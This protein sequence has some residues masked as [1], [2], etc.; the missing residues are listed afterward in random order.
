VSNGNPWQP[1]WPIIPPNPG[2][3]P[4][5]WSN[6]DD[7]LAAI[8]GRSGDLPK[9]GSNRWGKA[10]TLSN[11]KGG[12][13]SYAFV[14]VAEYLPEI[15]PMAVQASFSL[16]GQTF[17]PQV[18]L[19]YTAA[20][21]VVVTRAV[22]VKS[23]PFREVFVLNPGDAFPFCTTIARGM[24][25][26]IGLIDEAAPDIAVHCVATPTTMVDCE[27]L[28][29]AED[30]TWSDAA[31]LHFPA[32][33]VGVFVGVAAM[34]GTKQV[35]VQNNT[36]TDLLLGLGSVVPGNGPPPVSSIRL[37][38]GVNAVWESGGFVGQVRGIFAAVGSAT[39]YATF[40]RGF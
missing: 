20:L 31:T 4:G 32:S 10:Q 36:A 18:P 34:S 33:T 27:S 2:G 21:V 35:I 24:T 22:D 8:I 19:A 30:P 13:S 29:P 16:D 37:P 28:T 39:E 23:G 9:P 6:P 38:G 14:S 40:T 15:T 3:Q 12:Q 7:Q 25:I 1:S 5:G 11:S 17:T 26:T